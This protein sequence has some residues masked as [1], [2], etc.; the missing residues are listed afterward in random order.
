MKD[1]NHEIF[2]DELGDI[3]FKEGKQKIFKISKSRV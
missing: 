3:D 1:Q 2:Q